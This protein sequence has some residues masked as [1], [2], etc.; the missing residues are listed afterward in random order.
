MARQPRLD[1]PFRRR[2]WR[3]GALAAL[4][5][6]V[7]AAGTIAIPRVPAWAA[8]GD[9][10]ANGD[11][12]ATGREESWTTNGDDATARRLSDDAGFEIG[13][14]RD[15]YRWKVPVCVETDGDEQLID[16]TGPAEEVLS[17][18][19]LLWEAQAL[20][21]A[22]EDITDQ[23]WRP[24][25]RIAPAVDDLQVVGLETWLAIDPDV[26]VPIEAAG[27][28]GEVAVQA[29][30]TPV[31]TVWE[32]SDRT[33]R[34]EGPGVEY[35]P[36][37]QGP[38]PCGR[39]WEHTTAVE[40]MAMEVWI[41]YDVTWSSTV[42]GSGQLSRDGESIGVIDLDVGEI[43]SV[44]TL[45]DDPHLQ[46]PG[47]VD[48]PED[49]LRPECTLMMMARGDCGTGLPDLDS[50]PPS[51][52][53]DSGDDDCG[54]SLSGAWNCAKDA[55]GA[56]ADA[57]EQLYDWS[58]DGLEW[59][60][61][62]AMR[63]LGPLGELI[64][65][66]GEFIG[67]AVTGLWDAAKELV[68]AAGDPVAWAN[69]QYDQI[70]TMLAAIEQDPQGFAVEF[71]GEMAELDLLRENPARWIGKMGCE[72]AVALLTGG[73]AAGSGRIGRIFNKLDDIRD[74]IRRR[75]HHD[76]P[77]APD[78]DRPRDRDDDSDVDVCPINSFPTGTLVL[79]A[80]GS[81]TPIEAIDAGDRVLAADPVSGAWQPRAVL[82]Q[83]SAVD[84]GEMATITLTDGSVVTATDHHQFWVDGSGAWVDA[85]DLQP[86]DLLLTPDGVAT[87]AAVDVAAPT[88]TLVWEL[89]V[90]VDHS[91]AVST[92]STDVLVHNAG[93]SL[94]K[95]DR[96]TRPLS[97]EEL[98]HAF[99]RHGHELLNIPEHALSRTEHFDAVRDIIDRARRSGLTFRSRSGGDAT[100]AHLARVD[101]EYVVV[102]FFAEGDKAGQLASAWRPRG[103]QLG[104]YLDQASR[105]GP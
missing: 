104:R 67:E 90:A 98:E 40:P 52:D 34:C 101:G 55:A 18:L 81:S 80:D 21:E 99:D 50:Q 86:G 93:C 8:P 28:S 82:A 97:T 19:A 102:H 44:G 37:A 64:A 68:T 57:G 92:G 78:P 33:V 15:G 27:S 24:G 16:V 59:I 71:L 87:V 45:G 42:G 73:A 51:G 70:T 1:R 100:I 85:E 56:V 22:L 48:G 84:R 74:W 4:A 62:Q 29:R 58:V 25:V 83:W 76:G 69:E 14:S 105:E 88:T 61:E 6:V 94:D 46:D 5:F 36:G 60:G 23:A 79:M 41:E 77:D 3:V 95:S 49:D 43:Q 17:E 66:C 11:G 91:F 10:D 96:Q 65:G 75:N 38:A 89:T 20:N 13:S 12:N 7:V 54:F 35:T 31:A 9:C 2:R 32:F 39:E 72:L 53:G 26:Y 47:L 63:L 30:A 103:D